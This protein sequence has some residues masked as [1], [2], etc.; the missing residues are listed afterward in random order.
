MLLDAI[1]S[2]L[3]SLQEAFDESHV[4]QKA[5]SSAV[6]RLL[7]GESYFMSYD[8][9]SL[10]VN[11]IPT[12][13]AAELEKV[14]GGV[15][16]V[17]AVV[18]DLLHHYPDVSAGLTGPLS[19]NRDKI[20]LARESLNS[21]TL[22]AFSSVLILLVFVFRHK[23]LPF[24]AIAALA[25]GI[26]WAMGSA[27]LVAGQL[28]LMTSVM[29]VILIGLGIDFSIHLI[30]TYSQCRIAG[31]E[32]RKALTSMFV[33]SGRALFLAGMTTSAAFFSL[34]I[35]DS[36]GM[37]E[38][39]LVTG[40]G[41]LAVLAATLLFLPV[42]LVV[43]D[44]WG[45]LKF[46]GHGRRI[47]SV[48]FSGLFAGR[49]GRFYRVSLTVAVV[50][51]VLLGYRALRISFDRNSLHMEPG[52]LTSVVLQ[53]IV[54]AGF[55]LSMDYALVLSD[56]VDEERVAAKK[57]GELSSVAVVDGIHQYLP[58]LT[59]QETR[60]SYV[61]QIRHSLLRSRH[62]RGGLQVIVDELERLEMNVIELQDMAFLD[63]HVRIDEQCSL[64][65]G[66][67]DEGG[68]SSFLAGLIEL[69]RSS[70]DH[71][72]TVMRQYGDVFTPL[73]HDRSFAASSPVPIDY[74][75]LPSSIRGRYANRDGDCFMLT[76]FPE[77]NVW[78]DLGFL[79][80]F[81]EETRS[82]APKVS[83][84]PLVFDGLVTVM[85]R[86][87]G[88]AFSVALFV[89]LLLLWIDFKRLGDALLAMVPLIIGVIW[90]LGIMEIFGLQ[91]TIINVMAIALIVGIGIDDG[92]HIVHRWRSDRA[93]GIED[94]F[95]STGRAVFLTT[96]TT[97][98]AFGAL[99][100]SAW[101]S[102]VSLGGA[103]FIGAGSCYAATLLV[104]PGLM[105]VA[106]KFRG[107]VRI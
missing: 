76:V 2:W 24:F 67:P 20:I 45:L 6:D 16:A 52:N 92:V 37:K 103:L 39:G 104:L 107:G 106:E 28:N 78:K 101:P 87:A 30:H 9:R 33:I 47:S 49:L 31:L 18:R 35:S 42:M 99:T 105:A 21:T 11:V 100:F 89:V 27:F 1:R 85:M 79:R 65:I 26:I 43:A 95:E 32:C 93:G 80:V 62:V 91:L 5:V 64:I 29:G 96:L 90:M 74:D 68:A 63:G 4:S 69:I 73:F 19:L 81:S 57:S 15:N 66:D 83:G 94:V 25:V 56:S 59:E 13:T 46:S 61:E 86:D 98:I 12:F 88:I 41:L 70:G 82:I 58:S 8:R 17:E 23:V 14:T 34:M 22:V 102:F 97:M 3:L 48:S 51:T 36:R 55:D 40:T 84:I 10:I 72:E 71:G 75:M 60:R 54:A 44:G 77:R 53:D 7:Y 38:L 50:L